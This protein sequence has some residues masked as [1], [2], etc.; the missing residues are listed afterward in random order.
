MSIL[1]NGSRGNI[2]PVH[3]KNDKQC[4]NN[5]R[6]VSL[7]PI[8]GKI[9]EKL[10][11]NEIFKFLEAE[12][13]LN[14]NQSGFRPSDSC[15]NQL[16]AITYEIFSAFDWNLSLEVR[17][18]FLDPSKAFDRVWHKGLLFKLKSMGIG[19]DLYSLMDNYLKGRY[20]KVLL[21][22]QSS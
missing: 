5:Y 18:L 22:G 10:I 13:L 4:V 6:P 20:Q 14:P 8:C 17:G 3:K 2:I 19:G 11:F 7:L 15:I 16:I 9:F 1:T 21:N 12:N